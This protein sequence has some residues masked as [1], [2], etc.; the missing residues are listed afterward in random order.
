MFVKLEI[1]FVV[2]FYFQARE[3][4][5]MRVKID[6]MVAQEEKK[7]KEEK[8]RQLAQE[9]REER[10]GIRSR[11]R[12]YSSLFKIFYLELLFSLFCSHLFSL[13]YHSGFDFGI[14]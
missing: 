13:L 6:E 4:V 5:E 1:H 12:M 2:I 11:D 10:A 14:L 8:L 3:E 7:K 9:A